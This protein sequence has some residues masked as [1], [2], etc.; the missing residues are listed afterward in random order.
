[1]NVAS[2]KF[3]MIVYIENNPYPTI[4][5]KSHRPQVCSFFYTKKNGKIRKNAFL[6]SNLNRLEVSH[7]SELEQTVSIFVFSIKFVLQTFA[8]HFFRIRKY[9]LFFELK[10]WHTYRKLFSNALQVTQV[11]IGDFNRTQFTEL[12]LVRNS[13]TSCRY[14]VRTNSSLK[15]EHG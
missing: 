13:K 2:A 7:F 6:H 1:M 11:D 12:N 9:S 10:K 4:S 5:F 15:K 3:G 14:A 8:G